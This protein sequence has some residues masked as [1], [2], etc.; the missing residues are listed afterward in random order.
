MALADIGTLRR[1]VY[2]RLGGTRVTSAGLK[3]LTKLT[4]LT[5]LDI[6]AT[7]VDDQG[8]DAI[9]KLPKLVRL[10]L[11]GTVVSDCGRLE[12]LV[13]IPRQLHDVDVDGTKVQRTEGAFAL[14]TAG[15]WRGQHTTTL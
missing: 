3:S 10:Y 1:L 12:K 11:G 6:A 9:A 2:L 13:G 5:D 14:A 15:G 8:M 7:R 4:E